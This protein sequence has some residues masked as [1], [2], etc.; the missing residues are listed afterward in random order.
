MMVQFDSVQRDNV[1]VLFHEPRAASAAFELGQ[2]PGV[3]RAEPFRAALVRLRYE[4]RSNRS[5]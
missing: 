4:H 2:L 3:L 1:M 5:H